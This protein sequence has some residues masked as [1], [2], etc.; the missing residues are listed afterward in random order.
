MD[1]GLPLGPVQY[2]DAVSLFAPAWLTGHPC[3]L[4]ARVTQ[5]TGKAE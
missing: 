4:T 2:P 5:T 1:E 3:F